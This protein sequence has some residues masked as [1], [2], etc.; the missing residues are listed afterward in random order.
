M[1][2]LI[3]KIWNQVRKIYDGLVGTTINMAPIAIKVVEAIK[4]FTDSK[5]D[6]VIAFVIEKSI[7][8][9]ADDVLIEKVRETIEKWLP[10]ILMELA[11]IN[12]IAQVKDVNEQLKEIINAL[13][14]SEEDTKKVFYHGLASL[15]LEKLADGELDWSDATVIAEYVYKNKIE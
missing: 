6:D 11:I 5:A 4:K 13:N 14:I 15:I 2:K 12:S 8:G 7:P 3:Q 10:K 9:E 1:K